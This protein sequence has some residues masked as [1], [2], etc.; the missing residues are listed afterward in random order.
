[1]KDIETSQLPGVVEVTSNSGVK[2][3]WLNRHLSSDTGGSGDEHFRAG[4]VVRLDGPEHL[5]RRRAMQKLLSKGG[6]AYF[7]DTALFPTADELLAELLRR[8]DH[9]GFARVD[10]VPHARRVSQQLAAALVGFDGATSREGAAELHLLLQD[11]AAGKQGAFENSFRAFD[12]SSPLA[13][14]AIRAS[15]VIAER[16]YLPAYSRRVELAAQFEAGTLGEDEL[17]SDLLML[18]ALRADPAWEDEALRRR[19]AIFTL[20]AGVRTSS[21]SLVWTLEELF[22]WL[23]Q[24]PGDRALLDDDNFLLAV[25][26]EALRLHPVTPGFARRAEESVDLQDGT[27][28]QKGQ[29]VAIRSGAAG[30]EKDV[31]GPDAGDFNPHRVVAKGVSPHSFAFGAGPHICYGKPIVMG[32]EGIDGSLVHLLR[33]LMAA[34]IEPDPDQPR[35]VLEGSRGTFDNGADE[36]CHVRFPTVAR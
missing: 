17:P 11:Y 30:I 19:E 8:P 35:L 3:A 5:R 34:G 16:F 36:F 7:R 12:E 29:M 10:L 21:F 26:N 28:I 22:V 27:H 1:M 31:Y 33:R 24:H 23:D 2:E 4:T 6:H 18:M 20:G 13:Q 15:A 32:N 25:V 9:D 14:K